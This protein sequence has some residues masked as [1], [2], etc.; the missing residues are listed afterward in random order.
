[1]EFDSDMDLHDDS[2]K[3]RF[4]P[5][6]QQTSQIYLFNFT[7]KWSPGGDKH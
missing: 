7:E 4:I 6:N 1:M 2:W 5:A 3:P